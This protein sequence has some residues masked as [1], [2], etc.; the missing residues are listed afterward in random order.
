MSRQ[1]TADMLSQITDRLSMEMFFSK[2]YSTS[3]KRPSLKAIIL[4]SSIDVELLKIIVHKKY[5]LN[6]FNLII[7]ELDDDLYRAS[8]SRELSG[9][10]HRGIFLLDTKY[11]GV[12]IVY[13]N[14]NTY[15]VSH[16][17]ES[18]FDKLYPRISRVYF[19]LNQMRDF[20]NIINKEY[21]GKSSVTSFTIKR[22]EK[23]WKL[24]IRIPKIK[25]TLT[26]WEPDAE[27]EIEKLLKD[28]LIVIIR[29]N[30]DI[31]DSSGM[32][33]LRANITRKGKCS[34]HY[35]DFSNFTNK[36]IHNIIQ[37]GIKWNS[38]YS[39]RER[40]VIN[41]EIFI[42]P[43]SI[44]YPEN[45][46]Y[47]DVIKLSNKLSSKYTC[48]I[49]HN[50]NPYFVA[51]ISDYEEGSSFGVTAI[52]K[53]VT[54]TPIVKGT[55]VSTWKLTETIQQTLGDGEIIQIDVI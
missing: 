51:N 40:N 14:Y 26:L 36:V 11:E 46:D 7:D 45:I 31:K 18:F 54:I 35:G 3:S 8:L 25:G 19:N 6:S 21:E 30:F 20:V 27:K 37:Y 29:L 28:Y 33:L 10:K 22:E 5:E 4:L 16:V 53:N 15:Y 50:G 2:V 42:N 49:I 44:I 13:T 43:F 32:R 52:G 39:E 55:S 24:P 34:L 23:P 9:I 1:I 38:F 41:K 17:I 48:S 12:W 47:H